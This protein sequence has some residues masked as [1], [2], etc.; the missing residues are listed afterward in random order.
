MSMQNMHVFLYRRIDTSDP[1]D[2]P[3][4]H[5]LTGPRRR[6][7]RAVHG[8]LLCSRIKV[9]CESMLSAP[10]RETRYARLRYF[11]EDRHP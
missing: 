11:W 9:R 10:S 8:S 6:E 7:S 4:S 3:R 5:L 1:L 2:P